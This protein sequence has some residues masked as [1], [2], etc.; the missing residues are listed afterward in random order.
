MQYT[1]EDLHVAVDVLSCSD[2]STC[3]P[4]ILTSPYAA[5]PGLH[6]SLRGL[7]STR[8]STGGANST[9]TSQ[10]HPS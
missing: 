10:Q 3:Y 2:H 4:D 5:E 7:S 8:N 1:R 9:V 6:G